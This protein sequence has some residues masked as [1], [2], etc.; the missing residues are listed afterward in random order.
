MATS[1]IRIA[2]GA[3]TLGKPLPWDVFDDAGNVLL[4]QGCVIQTDTQLEQLFERGRF[5]PRKIEAPKKP[6]SAP[7]NREHNPFAEYGDLLANLDATLKAI[8]NRD[9]TAFKRLLNLA[10]TLD[11]MCRQAPDASLAL[12]HLYSISPTIQEQ[13]LCYGILCHMIARA[14]GLE[15]KRAQVLTAA[16]LT[17]NLALVRVADQLNASN[18]LL[19]ENQRQVIRKHPQRSVEA[20]KAAGI[21]NKLLHKIIAQ[22]HEQADGSGYPDGLSGTDILPEAEILAL[23]ERYVAM[24]TR[25]AYRERLN[26]TQAR[27]LIATLADGHLRPAIPRSLLTVLGEYPPGMLVRLVNGEVGV[28]TR[29]AVLARGPFV[30]AIFDPEGQ[31]YLESP[32]RDTSLLD[33]NVRAPEEPETLPSMDFGLLWGFRS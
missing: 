9:D 10:K 21:D 17:A 4:R 3:L 14:F 16:A 23:S 26:I 22:H 15:E 20:L 7:D 2:P 30:K 1:L 6:Q 13:M 32:E 11:S 19:T 12:V 33:F 25:R 27:K 29:R 18:K 5:K 31:R 24:I 8:A 28:V